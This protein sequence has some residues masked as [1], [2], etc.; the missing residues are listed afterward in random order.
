M[1]D[2]GAREPGVE[3]VAQPPGKRLKSITMLSGGE[4][5]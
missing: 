4:K 1:E 3:I 5:R 2:N